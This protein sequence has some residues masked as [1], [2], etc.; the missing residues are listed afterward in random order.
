M[1]SLALK[2]MIPALLASAVYAAPL[3]K[4]AV[5]ADAKWVVHINLDAF[6]DSRIGSLVLDEVHAEHQQ[7]IDAFKEL[8]GLDLTR[9]LF[10]VTLYGSDADEENAVALFRGRFDQQKLTS[11][12]KLNPTYTTSEYN[13]RTLHLWTDENSKKQ[14]AGAFA[15]DNLIAI[16]QTPEA[17]KSALDVLADKNASLDAAPLDPLYSLTET[18]VDPIILLAADSLSELT[19]NQEHAAVLQN[20]TML[21]FLAGEQEGDVT[22]HIDLTAQTT[23]AATQIEQIARGMI[24]FA[25]LQ[26]PNNPALGKILAALSLVRSENTLNLNFRYPAADLFDLCKSLEDMQLEGLPNG[27]GEAAE[28]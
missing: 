7:Q 27:A 2:I 4:Q 16:S 23:E 18:A 25:S 21:A 19:E 12:L 24:A 13:G 6:R 28:S 17:V 15:G 1:K 20:S 3:D 10:S 22:V 8:F 5:A 26:A 14:Q 9:D 11:L